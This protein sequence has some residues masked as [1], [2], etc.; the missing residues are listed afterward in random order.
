M[1]Q[2]L[3]DSTFLFNFSTPCLYRSP[4]WNAKGVELPTANLIPCFGELEGKEIFAELRAAWSEKGLLF[5]L[6]VRG[7]RQIPWCRDSRL[8]D[9]DGLQIWID[10]RDTHNIHRA[11]R[12]CHQFLFLPMGSGRRG[13]EPVA[14]MM[15]VNRAREESRTLNAA[16][17]PVVSNRTTD[18]YRMSVHIPAVCLTGFDPSEHHQLGFMYMVHDR[19]LGVQTFSMGPEFPVTEDPSTWGSLQLTQETK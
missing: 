3:I 1:S 8:L 6:T 9:S 12:F 11:T 13:D 15:K 18:G 19:E 16:K 4:L 17:M 5:D 10:T 7:K 14:T 2:P